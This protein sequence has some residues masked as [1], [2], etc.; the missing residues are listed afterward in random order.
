MS[1]NQ[2][3][4][5]MSDSPHKVR[6]PLYLKL[7]LI[8]SIVLSCGILLTHYRSHL[9]WKYVEWRENLQDIRAIPDHPMPE[10]DIP[11][12]WVECS[13]GDMTFRLPPEMTANESRKKV[14]NGS[15]GSAIYF[16][17][18]R[19]IFVS[20]NPYDDMQE[21]LQYSNSEKP[22]SFPQW[23]LECF[24]VG[25][26]D[27][28]WSMSPQDVQKHRYW[29]TMRPSFPCRSTESF[30][31]ENFDSLLMFADHLTFECQSTSSAI[32]ACI[33]FTDNNKNFDTD[34]VR[35]VC[36]SIEFASHEK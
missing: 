12:D 6:T 24:R 2:Q 10:L 36:Q 17:E 21:F 15:S 16:H 20:L 11:D 23:R 27:F 26:D 22:F 9:S 13:L 35:R 30:F 29:V 14:Y 19:K 18:G 8:A 5:M 33:L 25:A 31:R 28:R 1:T 3:E 32:G 34:V 4:Q 7:V